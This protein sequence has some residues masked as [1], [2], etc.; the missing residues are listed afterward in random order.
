[1]QRL[2]AFAATGLFPWLAAALRSEASPSSVHDAAA[3]ATSSQAVLVLPVSSSQDVLMG[4]KKRAPRRA[5]IASHAPHART[6]RAKPML[7]FG[8]RSTYGADSKKALKAEVEPRKYEM[9][10]RSVVSPGNALASYDERKYTVRECR[11]L[12][13]RHPACHS[14]TFGWG[15]TRSC[16]L[17]DACVSA[18]DT[19]VAEDSPIASYRTFYRNCSLPGAAKPSAVSQGANK[20]E[21]PLFL[22]VGVVTAPGYFLR[23]EYIRKAW[24]RNPN[25]GVGRPIEARFFVGEPQAEHAAALQREADEMGD[26]VQLPMH[27]SYDNLTAKTLELIRWAVFY[28]EAKFVM[29]MDDDTYPNFHNLLP[30]LRD[31]TAKYSLLGHIF[32]CAPVLNFTK[33]AEKKEVYNQPFYPTYAQGS[34]YILS[35]ELARD[36]GVTRYEDHKLTMLHNEDASVGLWIRR[37]KLLNIDL[38]DVVFKDLAARSTLYGCSENDLLSMNLQ[39]KQM[40]CMWEKEASGSRNVCCPE[41]WRGDYDKEAGDDVAFEDARR[42]VSEELHKQATL[43]G[44][45]GIPAGTLQLDVVHVRDRKE[46]RSKLQERANYMCYNS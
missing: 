9:L 37:D 31:T 22:F 18:N 10:M 15:L 1:M 30:I 17:Q 33:W 43:A 21:E 26:I 8:V 28:K 44:P 4:T 29:K 16:V 46:G 32:S 39:K 2:L 42:L 20:T 23:R 35:F 14:F 3:A 6:L 13:D 41:E 45:G 27:D 12:C 36:I 24:L 7:S 5:R 25:I 19:L 11:A 40:P 34:G 38:K